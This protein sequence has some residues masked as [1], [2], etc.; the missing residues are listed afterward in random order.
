M[1]SVFWVLLIY[2]MCLSIDGHLSYFHFLSFMN[3]NASNIHVQVFV[4]A[5]VFNSPGYIPKRRIDGLHGNSLFNLETDKFFFIV[6]TQFYIPNRN[7]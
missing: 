4:C 2:H 7:V 3:N 6:V 1:N 5:Y